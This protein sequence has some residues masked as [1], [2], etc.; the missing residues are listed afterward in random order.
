MYTIRALDVN[1]ALPLGLA[2]LRDR[3]VPEDT[4]NGPALV[5]PG[6][7][8]TVYDYPRQRVLF[9]AKR[10]ANPF[11]HLFESMWILHGE[12]DVRFLSWFNSRIASYSD[13]GEV[14]HGAYGHRLR[15]RFG[16]DQIEAA[17]NMLREDYNT[18]RVVLAIWDPKADLGASS[19]DLPCNDMVMARVRIDPDTLHPSRK[20]LDITVCNRSND[21]VWGAYGANAVQFSFLQE[22]L[23]T[24]IGVGV[25]K[26][27]QSSFN[28]HVYTDLPYWKSWLTESPS[29]AYSPRTPYHDGCLTTPL[30]CHDET[31]EQFD[32]DLDRF[33]Y[34]RSRSE[35]LWAFVKY[36]RDQT[37]LTQ[38]FGDTVV[39]MLMS[40]HDRDSSRLDRSFDWGLAGAEWIERRKVKPL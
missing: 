4:R 11:F 39:S 23:A 13:D 12:S 18:R 17:V 3:G 34:I 36:V 9:S 8:A 5:A 20:V 35:G 38:F 15:H 22:Y 26:Y 27:T 32:M 37:F 1:E 16:V 29:G 6:P 2:Y 21:A 40:Y 19:K 7:V 33:F 28:F 30:I 14:F 31:A 10:D 24:R 25:G